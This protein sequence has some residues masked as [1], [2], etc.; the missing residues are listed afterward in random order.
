MSASVLGIV[1]L[2]AAAAWITVH[3][4]VRIDPRPLSLPYLWA[5][6]GIGALTG[7]FVLGGESFIEDTVKAGLFIFLSALWFLTSLP[8]LFPCIGM[9]AALVA[10]STNYLLRELRKPP[11]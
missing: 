6:L 5:F 8:A 2:V 7:L 4:A 11:F 1:A 3:V 10:F 9:A